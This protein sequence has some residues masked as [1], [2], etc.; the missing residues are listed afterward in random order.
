MAIWL[1]LQKSKKWL[2]LINVHFPD[3]GK[4]KSEKDAFWRDFE[5]CVSKADE[6]DIMV[7]VGDFNASMGVSTSEYDLATSLHGDQQELRLEARKHRAQQLDGTCTHDGSSMHSAWQG[8]PGSGGD[9]LIIAKSD[10]EVRELCPFSFC[11]EV[12]FCIQR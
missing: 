3:G 1:P 9:L 6:S 2:Y 5:T 10:N 4:L 8:A 12:G 11:F 7:I